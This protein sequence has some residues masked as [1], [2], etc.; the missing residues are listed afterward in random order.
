M[1]FQLSGQAVTTKSSRLLHV[2]ACD[3]AFAAAAGAAFV[4]MMSSAA[5]ACEHVAS[6]RREPVIAVRQAVRAIVPPYCQLSKYDPFKLPSDPC[7]P[8]LDASASDL[9][10]RNASRLVLSIGTVDEVGWPDQVSEGRHAA[11]PQ[12]IS[13][14]LVADATCAAKQREHRH[15]GRRI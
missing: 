15:E 1:P 12:R 10:R 5:D 13:K 3:R 2:A 7:W 6:R 9:S 4:T 11:R 14:Q 8:L